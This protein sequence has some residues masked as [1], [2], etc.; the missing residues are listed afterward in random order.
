MWSKF[1]PILT[2]V[3]RCNACNN[4]RVKCSGEQPCQRC[5]KTS[6]DCEYTAADTDRTSIKDELERL[7]V[8]CAVLEDGLRT[9]APDQ[10]PDLLHQLDRGEPPNWTS[11]VLS[12]ASTL[13]IDESR[14]SGGRLL[15]DTDGTLRYLGESSGATF[16]DQLKQFLSTLIVPLT[17]VLASGDGCTFMT[18]IGHYQTFDSRP[19]PS[20]DVNAHWLPSRLEMAPMLQ[21][22]RKYIQDGDGDFVSGGTHWWGDLNTLPSDPASSA[23]MVALTTEETRRHLAFHN[24]CFALAVS[25]GHTSLR[26]PDHQSGESYFMRARLLL[27]NPL[28]TVRFTLSDVPALALMGLYLIEVNRRD[29]AYIYVGLAV[30]IAIIHGSFRHTADEASK[31]TFWTLYIMDRWI[32]ML[33][34]RPPIIP[35]EAIRLPLP[36]DAP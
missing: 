12:P 34:G 1:E 31:R 25:I 26:L 29:A 7:R 21:E 3:I 35:D 32:S 27:G 36:V 4:R 18:S 22:L 2:E 24:V 19:L 16:L 15:Y 28:D 30:H 9:I 23:S 17:S 10:A 20:P 33:M 8:R 6:R 11:V 14:Q 13:S 5:V